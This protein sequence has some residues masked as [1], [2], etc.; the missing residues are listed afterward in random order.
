M[1]PA[2]AT[3]IV[4]VNEI[5]SGTGCSSYTLAL[6]GLPCAQPSLGIEG[7]T[8]PNAHLFWPNSAGGYL[9][10]SSPL[11]QPTAWSVVT[12]EPI[13]NA[14]NYNVTNVAGNPSQYYRLHKT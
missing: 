11:I 7:L 13:I 10:E 2:G 4:V 1:I 8:G 6:S 3:F 14:G 5:S 12:N 9:L